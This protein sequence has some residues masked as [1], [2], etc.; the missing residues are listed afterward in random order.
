[1]LLSQDLLFIIFLDITR[2]TGEANVGVQDW[3]GLEW[4]S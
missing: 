2:L 3:T 1:M 4:D